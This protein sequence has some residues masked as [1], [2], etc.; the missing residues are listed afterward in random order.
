VPTTESLHLADALTGLVA[1]SSA[2]VVTACSRAVRRQAVR[3]LLLA[4]LGAAI[5]IAWSVGTRVVDD[6]S[7]GALVASIAVAVVAGV[8]WARLGRTHPIELVATT[9]LLTSIGVWLAV[10]DT[11]AAVTCVA[12]FAPLVVLALVASRRVGHGIGWGD[13][14][15]I[16]GWIG[17]AEVVAW[18]AAWGSTGRTSTLPGALA[19]FGVA[20]VV[21]WIGVLS[22]RQVLP[23]AWLVVVQLLAIVA[24]ARWAARAS[25]L[26][27][28]LLRALA[29]LAVL[30][31]VCAVSARARGPAHPRPSDPGGRR[32]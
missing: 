5:A 31:L 16:L 24:A 13:G 9:V 26:S 28:G 12:A 10:P 3:V 30:A 25:T 32:R 7:V 2:A 6:T 1:G 4:A 21:P 15:A 18:A 20:L 27:G 17:V 23:G 8:G 14:L 29:V 11:E 19:G 22:G